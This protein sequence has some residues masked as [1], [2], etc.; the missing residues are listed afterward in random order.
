MQ[1]REPWEVFLE[2]W[3]A[4]TGHLPRVGPLTPVPGE[5]TPAFLTMERARSRAWTCAH[6]VHGWSPLEATLAAG[7]MALTLVEWLRADGADRE[8]LGRRLRS[9]QER[10]RA[11]AVLGIH[12]LAQ[13]E[14]KLAMQLDLNLQAR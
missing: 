11:E 5:S 7:T 4:E 12:A 14:A 6:R 2:C 13:M 8:I 9:A 3:S 1:T 10:G